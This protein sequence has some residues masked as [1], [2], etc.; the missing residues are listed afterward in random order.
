MN[1]LHLFV[2]FY[3]ALF[4]GRHDKNL[5]DTRQSFQASDEYLQDFLNTLSTLSEQSKAKLVREMTYEEVK[6][7]VKDCPTGRSPGLDGVPFYD[8]G[9]FHRGH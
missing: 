7:I 2:K 3:E 6:Q 8:W 1:L 5:N 4:N 9:E